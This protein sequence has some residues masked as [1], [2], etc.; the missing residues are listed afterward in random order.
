MRTTPDFEPAARREPS[1]L[2]A[3]APIG[4]FCAC[5]RAYRFSGSPESS[6]RQTNSMPSY[7][8]VAF[9]GVT[10]AVLQRT[11]AFAGRPAS[12]AMCWFLQ[13]LNSPLSEIVAIW[14]PSLLIVADTTSWK[15]LTGPALGGRGLVRADRSA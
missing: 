11:S 15:G 3:A 2:N 7:V 8:I 12:P 5:G 10:R 9:F 4:S 13:R 6:E 14:L 1:G